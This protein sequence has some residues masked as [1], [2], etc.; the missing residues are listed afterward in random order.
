MITVFVIRYNNVRKGRKY[1]LNDTS[2]HFI[3]VQLMDIVGNANHTVSISVFWI[4]DSNDEKAL[5]LVKESLDIIS[6]T[7]YGYDIYAGFEVVY[8]AVSYTNPNKNL[9]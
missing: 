4:Y 2:D 6:S 1:I 9:S 3:L 7:F 8:Y 5:S